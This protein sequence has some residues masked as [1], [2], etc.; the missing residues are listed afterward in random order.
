MRRGERGDCMYFVASGEL[1]LRGRRE[2]ISY[3]PGDFFGEL[4]LLT[5]AP[6]NAM[7]VATQACTLLSLDIV[8]FRQ[9]LGRQP[10]LARIILEEAKRR[11]EATPA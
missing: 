6:R 4:A 5:G 11:L 10:D 2:A 7:I 9:L 8:D 1:E 3:C